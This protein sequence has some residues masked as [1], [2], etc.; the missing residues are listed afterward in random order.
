MGSYIALNSLKKIP[1]KELG[2]GFDNLVKPEYLNMQSVI[3]GSVANGG[4]NAKFSNEINNDEF[5]DP[6]STIKNIWLRNVHRVVI[7]NLNIN[8][9][10]NNFNQLK[11]LVLKYVVILDLTILFQIRSFQLMDSLNHLGLTEID[12]EVG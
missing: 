12:L 3:N 1:K 4:I 5:L 6:L 8:S 10:T 7:G 11:E 9:L 2:L